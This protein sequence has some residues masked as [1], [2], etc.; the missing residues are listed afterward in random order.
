[1]KSLIVSLL[2]VTGALAQFNPYFQ[3]GRNGIV[4]LFEWRWDDIAAGKRNYDCVIIVLT[5]S[6]I[7]GR[8]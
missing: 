8:V 1:M 7:I 4:H 3:A 2:V 5:T 6:S